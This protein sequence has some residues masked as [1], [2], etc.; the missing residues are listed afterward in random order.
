M[1]KIEL[2]KAGSARLNTCNESIVKVVEEAA[3]CSPVNFDVVMGA[4]T[5]DELKSL[6]KKRL[7]S[8]NPDKF[9][10]KKLKTKVKYSKTL[11]SLVPNLIEKKS[12]KADGFYINC[13]HGGVDGLNRT[14]GLILGTANRVLKKESLVLLGVRGGM[15]GFELIKD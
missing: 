14:I 1:K 12:D 7:F 8:V 3:S 9:I 6:N 5:V 2:T 4:I 10:E 11:F 15:A 13:P